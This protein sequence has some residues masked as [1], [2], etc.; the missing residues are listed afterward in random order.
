MDRFNN[1]SNDSIMDLHVQFPCATAL[2]GVMQLDL[3]VFDTA[4]MQDIRQAKE[5]I[6]DYRFAIDS[7]AMLKFT[8]TEA[9]ENWFETMFCVVTLN[10]VFV[11][12]KKEIDART[13][14]A[15]SYMNTVMVDGGK[16][17]DEIG[18]EFFAD[19]IVACNSSGYAFT[20]MLGEPIIEHIEDIPVNR[21]E[22]EIACGFTDSEAW[23]LTL[24][25][26]CDQEHAH[27]AYTHDGYVDAFDVNGSAP[28]DGLGS[29]F[30]ENNLQCVQLM[31]YS[32]EAFEDFV[33]CFYGLM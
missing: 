20:Y 22:I 25:L 4:D 31:F 32:Q 19:R 17:H 14:K 29:T 30:Y 13:R 15:L 21:V 33:E 10:D 1:V 11:E 24:N 23:D 6:C 3:N 27:F 16:D 8:T 18:I 2:T 12:W 28:G 9:F 7:F 5:N 26:E